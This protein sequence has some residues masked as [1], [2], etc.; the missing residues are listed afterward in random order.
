M[1]KLLTVFTNFP[2]MSNISNLIIDVSK[3]KQFLENLKLI[4]NEHF[5]TYSR[6]KILRIYKQNINQKK[7][8]NYSLIDYRPYPIIFSSAS[9]L[10]LVKEIKKYELFRI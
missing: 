7:V 1:T 6:L 5:E 3:M 9:S 10:S 4:L 8:N 2:I